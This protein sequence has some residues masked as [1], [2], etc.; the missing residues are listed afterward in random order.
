MINRYEVMWK[1]KNGTFTTMM[2]KDSSFITYRNARRFAT[3]INIMIS[4]AN[5]EKIAIVIDRKTHRQISKG[6]YS[7]KS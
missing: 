3:D 5:A 1:E 6:L 7:D 4:E 2:F